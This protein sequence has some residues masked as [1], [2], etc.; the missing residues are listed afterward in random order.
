MRALYGPDGIEHAALEALKRLDR[1]NTLGAL[2][3]NKRQ[4]GCALTG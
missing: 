1:P 2:G 4:Q 3:L